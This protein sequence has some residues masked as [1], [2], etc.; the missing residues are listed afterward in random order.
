MLKQ[1][2][3]T[4]VLMM[5][6]FMSLLLLAPWQWFCVAISAVFIIGAWEWSNLSGIKALAARLVYVVGLSLIAVALLIVLDAGQNHALMQSLMLLACLW[7]AVALLWVQSYP[8]SAILWRPLPVRAVLGA[9]VLIPAWMAVLWLRQQDNGVA[10]I[11]FALLL[12]AA[13]DIGAYFAG[14]AL[15]KRKLA[16]NVSPGKTWAGVWGGLLLSVL[17]GGAYGVFLLGF[18]AVQM[19]VLIVPVAATSVLGDLLESMMKRE[20]GIKDSSS[21]LPGHGGI[22][23]RLDGIVAALPVLVLMLLNTN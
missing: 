13:A 21:I 7:W 12:V 10:L 15:G 22:L 8:S 2:V 18:S 17:L 20:R 9:L 14:R 4:A 6:V 5:T 3:I 11:F 16:P 1:R 23:D 19:L